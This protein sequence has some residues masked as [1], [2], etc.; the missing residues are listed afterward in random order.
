VSF[1]AQLGAQFPLI[2]FCPLDPVV[3]P[4]VGYGG[5]PQYMQLFGADAPWAQAASRVNVFKI[6]PQ[7]ITQAS[8]ADLQAQFSG[9]QRRGIKLALEWGMLNRSDT[10]G[11]GVE[12]FGG[13]STLNTVRRIQ[14][15]GGDL[16]Y[17][18]MDEPIFFGTLYKGANACRWT[19][20]EM[21]RN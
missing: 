18:A 15:L 20:E 7:W 17:I 4:E 8:D 14:R 16:R 5:S 6:Y 21:A 11:R 3:R 13:E 10:C 12:G 9:L 19:V 2:W 1:A